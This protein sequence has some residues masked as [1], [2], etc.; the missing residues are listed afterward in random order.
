MEHRIPRK[1]KKF[2]KNTEPI[3]QALLEK[4]LMPHNIHLYG[5]S[6]Q[7][8]PAFVDDKD[9]DGL[10]LIWL[11]SMNTRPQYYILRIDSSIN[12]DAN[13]FD[14]EVLLQLISE[15]FGSTDYYV[16]IDRKNEL[17]ILEGD[18]NNPNTKKF[19]RKDLSFPMLCWE[20]GSWGLIKNF[21]TGMTGVTY[22]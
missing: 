2:R 7:V 9:S 17:Y 16:C 15:K 20:S 4:E 18:P 21:R 8:A 3:I 1:E 22:Q 6:Y 14:I 11:S 10:Q 12:L 5:E 19:T 13:N